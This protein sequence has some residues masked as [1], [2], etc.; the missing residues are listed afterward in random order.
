LSDTTPGRKTR[1]SVTLVSL[2]VSHNYALALY[3]LKLY[4]R[5]DPDLREVVN[6][7]LIEHRVGRPAAAVAL[8]IAATRPKLVGFSCNVWNVERTLQV[9]ALLK[10]LLPRV[11]IVLGGQEITHSEIDYLGQN[12]AVDITVDGEGEEAFR[13]VLR[14][15]LLKGEPGLVTIPGISFRAND[16]VVVNPPGPPLPDLDAIP[17]PYLQNEIAVKSDNHLGIMIET[18]RGCRFRCTFCF[19]G[20]KYANVRNFSMD[21]VEREIADAVAKGVRH[22]HFLDPIVGNSSIPRLRQLHEVLTKHLSHCSWYQCSVEIYAELIDEETAALLP[23]FTHFDVGLQSINPPALRAIKRAF[24]HE[25]FIN[26]V[27]L[28]QALGRQINIYLLL[29]LP[30]DNFFTFLEAVRYT[31]SLN[32]ERLFINA[33]CVLNGTELRADAPRYRMDFSPKPPY[34]INSN[35]TFSA[36]EMKMA[37]IFANS[38]VK[39]HDAVITSWEPSI[40]MEVS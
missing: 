17:S 19:E 37:R 5:E 39:E 21:R 6:F 24:V 28:L 11:V 9:A 38:I 32:I 10:R 18:S 7:H 13:R 20:K 15:C 2:N 33:L 26:G 14:C 23:C 35:A 31:H 12:P 22:F 29:G 3:Y 4:A 34:L 36:Q 27:R 25:R 16:R 1:A 40:P 30:E 8:Q